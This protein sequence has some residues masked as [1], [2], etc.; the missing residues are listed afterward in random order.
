MDVSGV[1]MVWLLSLRF[2]L[3]LSLYWEP[4]AVLR[5]GGESGQRKCFSFPLYIPCWLLLCGGQPS[6]VLSLPSG[7]LSE[8]MVCWVL[9]ESFL[10]LFRWLHGVFLCLTLFICYVMITDSLTVNHFH[11]F[12][13]NP[14]SIMVHAFCNVLLFD[15]QGRCYE[16]VLNL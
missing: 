11:I 3:S 10:Y 5:T 9:S 2:C 1:G 6:C 16:F 4:C 13:M 15:L 7:L 8:G 12:R 14:N